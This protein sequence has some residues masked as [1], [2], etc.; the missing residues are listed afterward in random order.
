MAI[1]ADFLK[2][3]DENHA[4]MA[5]NQVMVRVK[6]LDSYRSNATGA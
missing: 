1:S 6:K 4:N 3:M 2:N 5:E